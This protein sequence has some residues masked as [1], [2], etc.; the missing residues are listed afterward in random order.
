MRIF[1][2]FPSELESQADSIAQSLRNCDHQVFFSHDDLP[3]GDSFDARV[4]KAIESSDFMVFLISPE[5]VTRGRYTLSELAFAKTKWP[6]PSNRVLPVMMAPT[7]LDQVPTYLRAVTIL[8]PQGSAA[9]ETRAAVDRML[10]ADSAQSRGRSNLPFIALALASAIAC[11]LAV[12]YATGLL[13][14]S[15][16]DSGPYGGITILPG[17]IFGVVV[18]TCNFIFGIKDRFQLLLVIAITAAAWISAFDASSVTL[19]TLGQYSKVATTAAADTTAA[20]TTAA[21]DSSAAPDSSAA[22]AT[23]TSAAEVRDTLTNNP[24]MG[25]V[26][27]GVGG[28]VGGAITILGI[29]LTNPSFRRLNSVVMTWIAA[30]AA[31]IVYGTVV[32]LPDLLGWLVLFGVWQPVFVVAMARGFPNGAAQIPEWLGKIT[33]AAS[34][35]SRA[36]R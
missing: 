33:A 22:D 30:V 18:A 6:N 4:E 17:V 32:K 25:Y 16:V 3:A 11:T 21:A 2:S 15:F 34:L 27:G 14:F 1:L 7:P 31:G 13:R 12:K 26:I 20:D 9:A 35:G 19:Q 8:E 29:I 36:A 24:F 10:A 5:S 23:T 28:A